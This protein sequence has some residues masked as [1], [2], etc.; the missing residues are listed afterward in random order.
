[1]RVLVCN[2]CSGNHLF[3][4]L[5]VRLILRGVPYCRG[6]PGGQLRSSQQLVHLEWYRGI[7]LDYRNMEWNNECGGGGGGCKI[8]PI[9]RLVTVNRDNVLADD[10]DWSYARVHGMSSRHSFIFSGLYI[11]FFQGALIANVQYNR[12]QGDVKIGSQY[13]HLSLILCINWYRAMCYRQV[14]PLISNQPITVASYSQQTISCGSQ[15]SATNTTQTQCT[16]NA[17]PFLRDH[18]SSI[19]IFLLPFVTAILVD[20]LVFQTPWEP[21]TS[22]HCLLCKMY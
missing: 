4:I 15:F 19:P 2:P 10:N 11:T 17:L 7:N 9:L 1:M 3:V 22:C 16:S 6:D 5:L 14:F 21:W 18:R 12:T 8:W 13:V 20:I